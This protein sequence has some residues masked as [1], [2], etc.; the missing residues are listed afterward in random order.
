MPAPKPTSSHASNVAANKKPVHLSIEGDPPSLIR[1][2][3]PS[4][5]NAILTTTVERSSSV[6]NLTTTEVQGRVSLSFDTRPGP[7]TTI[8]LTV[9]HPGYPANSPDQVEGGSDEQAS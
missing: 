9:S 6:A 4:Q 7:S 5:P 1:K 2:A 3:E 8:R